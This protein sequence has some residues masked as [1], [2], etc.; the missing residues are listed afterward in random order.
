M[1]N[2]ERM[3]VDERYKYLRKQQSRYHK[4]DRAGKGR[5]LDEM[6]VVTG[7]HRKSLIRLM[8][9]RPER[10]KRRRQ[11]GLTYGS[12]VKQAVLVVA[13]ATD[14]ACAERLKFNLT[15]M[16]EHL[17][18]H[19]EVELKAETMEALK[20]IS[21]STVRRMLS[22]LPQ[23]QVRLPRR[24]P[25]P[26]PIARRVAVA[27]IPWD[28]EEAGHVEIDLVHH[29][30][31]SSEGEYL[32]TL[33]LVDVASGWSE[34]AVVPG[35]SYLA[36]S[37]A[38]AHILDLLPFP[39]LE[40]HCDNGSEFLNCHIWTFWQER[41][42]GVKLTRSRPYHKNDNRLVEQRNSTLVRAYLGYG[43]LASPQQAQLLSRLYQLQRLY[44]NLFQPVMHLVEKTYVPGTG[45]TRRR[46]D[47]AATPLDR[48]LA[49]GTTDAQTRQAWE[50][51][52]R[53]INP[54]QMRETIYALRDRLLAMPDRSG[55]GDV[56]VL[57]E[58]LYPSN[59]TIPLQEAALPR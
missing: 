59:T 11:R 54:L 47:Q 42:P 9:S 39:V 1:P 26:N 34:R 17:E 8:T 49:L 40:V 41:Q 37:T 25:T 19:G 55:P 2:E 27:R 50:E 46:Y 31:G 14:W 28:V 48:L 22:T 53:A 6:E 43:R 10:K 30:G 51:K 35:R 21:A 58:S 16:A 45:T 33:Q 5:L 44:H 36:V 29:A 3:T 32:H 7:L 52:R 15:W 12:E 4:A 24:S 13:E 57:L 38:L 18:H 20:R 23:P 56:R